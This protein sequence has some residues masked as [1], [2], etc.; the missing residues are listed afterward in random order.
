MKSRPAFWQH[1][2]VAVMVGIVGGAWAV[3]EEPAQ[4]SGVVASI[5][6]LGGI[7]TLQES[8]RPDAVAGTVAQPRSFA[9]DAST[10]IS[11]DAQRLQLSDVRAG[12]AVRVE[13][14]TTDGQDVARSITIQS[15]EGAQPETASTSPAAASSTSASQL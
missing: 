14:A 3:A 10:I 9:V 5:D 13:Y 1:V 7:V 6:A 8:P 12:D 2:A 4:I 11:R 15:P